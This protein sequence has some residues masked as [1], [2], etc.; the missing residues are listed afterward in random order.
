MTEL[1]LAESF[2]QIPADA[3]D[4]LSPSGAAGRPVD[5]FTT[6]RFLMALESSGSVGQR[7]GWGAHPLL[8]HD[9]GRL[10]AALP[11]WAKSH[12][13]GEYV[14]DHGWAEAYARAGGSYYPKLQVAVPFTPVTG[15]RFLGAPEYRMALASAAIS[16]ARSNRLSSLHIT[17]CT[18]AEAQSLQ[19]HD[20]LLLRQGQQ[21]HWLNRGY[22]CFDD[23][24]AELS[25][26]KRK[27]IR[28][29]REGARA[30][31]L[32]IESLSGDQIRPEHWQAFWAFY[33][34][35]GSRKW[36]RPYL[37]REAFDAFG[38]TMGDDIL[39]VLAFDGETPVAGALNF[40]GADTLFGRYWGA[41]G[42]YPFLH[43]ELCYYQAIDYAIARGLS[44]VEAGAQG[45]HKLARGYLPV[46][47]FSLHWIHDPGFRQAVC[48]F[49][50]AELRAV[51][52]EIEILT[53]YGP[54]R[55]SGQG[56]QQ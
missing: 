10:V 53:R 43:F 35:T 41:T 6:H 49:L 17:F 39:L 7:S 50:Q 45:E 55:R 2:S 32:R 37:T 26:R 38:Q 54:F 40:I 51:D 16:L 4:A 20:G 24:L 47:T 52:D 34:D 12:S 15:P 8:L 33:Q 11:L 1:S 56:E 48:D 23:F 19:G 21:F 44:R 30:L 3:W 31:G 36:G 28:K 5:P 18:A 9:R 29:E 13:Q 25:S 42:D 14:F 46:P 27:M 22:G